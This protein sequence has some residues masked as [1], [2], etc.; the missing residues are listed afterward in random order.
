MVPARAL[1][2]AVRTSQQ[3]AHA[4][5][6]RCM[7]SPRRCACSAR[8]RAGA[9]A[10]RCPARAAQCRG[11]SVS[12][13]MVSYSALPHLHHLRAAAPVAACV[14]RWMQRV[15]GYRRGM[16]SERTAASALPL[17]SVMLARA[18]AR[19]ATSAV[20]LAPAHSLQ[21]QGRRCCSHAAHAGCAAWC[22]WP[23]GAAA[24]VRG[25]RMQVR[26]SGLMSTARMPGSHSAVSERAQVLRNSVSQCLSS[27]RERR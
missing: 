5:A 6:G 22:R 14:R 8:A 26:C 17:L 23:R 20:A 2:A 27:A 9:S 25:G 12:Q 7:A 16:A 21:E 1:N 19:D 15:A 11:Q 24:I 10:P 4:A 3:R 18:R 13:A